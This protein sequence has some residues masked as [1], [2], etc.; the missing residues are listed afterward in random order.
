MP[1]V[2]IRDLPVPVYRRLRERA[3]Q[4]RRSITREAALILEEALTKP[5]AAA[6]AWA[7]VD[8]VRDRLRAR[9]GRFDDS[10]RLIRQDR[11]R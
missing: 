6:D 11:R 3:N 10:T 4:N 9:Y 7:A 5:R 1:T 8:A 2:Y